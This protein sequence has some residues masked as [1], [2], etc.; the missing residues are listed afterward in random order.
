MTLL[1]APQYDERRARRRRL[2]L[3]LLVAL[4]IAAA[5]LAFLFRNWP[6]ERV[7]DRFFTALEQKDYER[8]YGLWVADP[9]WKQHPEKHKDYPFGEFYIDWGPG[10]EWG[11]VRSHEVDC[12]ARI[13][14]G[15]I[16]RVTVNER[17]EKAYLWV[18]KKDKTLTVAPSHFQLQ[19]G[20]LFAR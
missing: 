7:A 11:L 18:E 16:V 13:G 8:A 12:S 3:I 9:Q 4:V 5:I 14:S 1:D 20:G 6:Y 19:C 17:A 15:V 2:V 10:G